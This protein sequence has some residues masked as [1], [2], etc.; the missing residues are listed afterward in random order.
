MLKRRDKKTILKNCYS[1]IRKRY[2]L[3]N[4]KNAETFFYLMLAQNLPIGETILKMFGLP[5]NTT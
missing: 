2:G 3:Q 4:D 5:K 1:R